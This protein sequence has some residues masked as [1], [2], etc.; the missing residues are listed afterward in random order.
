MKIGI[1]LT[2]RLDSKRLP[3]KVLKKINGKEICKYIYERLEMTNIEKDNIIFATSDEKIDD[4]IVKFCSKNSYNFYRGPKYN[5]ALR[6]LDCAK[7]YN[8]NAFIRINGDNV[9]TDKKI[10]NEMIDIYK[11][12]E[13]DIITN[14]PGRTFPYGLSVEIIRTKFYDNIYPYITESSDREHVTTYIYK[15]IHRYKVYIYKSNNE[16]YKDV[17]ISLDNE[18]DFEIISKII[19]NFKEDHRNYNI[20]NIVELYYSITKKN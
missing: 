20:D 10:I 2:L 9:F 14:V 8:F 17:K 13:F 18:K 7:Y 11:N 6:L 5:V 1:I 15:N 16:K 3:G 19:N 12:E 4:E